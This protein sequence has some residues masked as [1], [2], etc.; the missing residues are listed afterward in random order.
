MC[1]IAT[2]AVAQYLVYDQLIGPDAPPAAHYAVRVYPVTALTVFALLSLGSSLWLRHDDDTAQHHE[3][4]VAP[5]RRIRRAARRP[6]SNGRRDELPPSSHDPGRPSRT[7]TAAERS[8]C[9]SR[10]AGCVRVVRTRSPRYVTNWSASAPS[11]TPWAGAARSA[12]SQPAP[13]G[14]GLHGGSDDRSPRPEPTGEGL[15]GHFRSIRVAQS[16]T[17]AAQRQMRRQGS[18]TPSRRHSRWRPNRPRCLASNDARAQTAATAG[19]VPT[20]RQSTATQRTTS[21]RVRANVA[22]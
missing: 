7:P 11:L 3:R 18:L 2:G 10:G 22:L 9:S 14:S 17:R 8:V 15:V 21:S 4:W 1:L 20:R 12:W 5:S 13:G 6:R 16:R 19:T